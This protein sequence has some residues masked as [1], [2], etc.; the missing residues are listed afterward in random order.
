MIELISI[1]AGFV[2]GFAVFGI[3]YALVD[4]FTPDYPQE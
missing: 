3:S 2:T 4:A 1:V